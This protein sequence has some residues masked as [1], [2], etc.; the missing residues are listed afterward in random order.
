M[1]VGI[2]LFGMAVA[3]TVQYARV[4]AFGIEYDGRVLKKTATNGGK[5]GM[6][7]AIDYAFSVDSVQHGGHVTVNHDAYEELTEGDPMTVRALESDPESSPWPRVPGHSA[8][9][10]VLGSWAIALIWNGFLSVAVW[11]TYIRPWRMRAL[12]RNGTPVV[13]L[14]RGWAPQPGKGGTSYRLTYDYTSEDSSGLSEPRSGKMTTRRKEAAGYL[15]GRLATVLYD[16]SKPARS[17][18]YA[19][20]DYRAE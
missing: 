18:I 2:V 12:V 17:V 1:V 8:P 16:P 19:L 15:P 10:E 14:I 11:V 20:G 4:L 9:L 6:H 5:S 3:G 7:Y 13:G